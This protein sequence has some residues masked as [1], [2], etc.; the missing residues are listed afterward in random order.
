M[1]P[2]RRCGLQRSSL[3]QHI[4]SSAPF[5][6]DFLRALNFFFFSVKLILPI[7]PLVQ[8]DYVFGV[9]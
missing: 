1:S 6:K 7:V 2:V 9:V 5:S 8:M 3:I 4:V